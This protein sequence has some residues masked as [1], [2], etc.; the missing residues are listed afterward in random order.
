MRHAGPSLGL[1]LGIGLGIAGIAVAALVL[2]G[3][4]SPSALSIDPAVAADLSSRGIIVSVARS[5]NVPIRSEQA[6]TAALSH[7]H[8]SSR[9]TV[10]AAALANVIVQPNPA[11]N[12]TCWVLSLS[13][14]GGNLVGPPGLDRKAMADHLK[15]YTRYYVAFV[16]A[17]TGQFEF[18]VESYIPTSPTSP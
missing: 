2:M 5:S 3:S 9:T 14:P 1:P 4:S 6:R 15:S 18:S 8:D 7:S 16:N 17:Q 11:F 13:G 10:R 12:C